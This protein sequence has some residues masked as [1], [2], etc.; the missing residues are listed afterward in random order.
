MHDDNEV[1]GGSGTARVL[2]GTRAAN[3]VAFA[4]AMPSSPSRLVGL[5][6]V[7]VVESK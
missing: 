4:T 5:G 1:C 6:S 3:S 2:V 7:D